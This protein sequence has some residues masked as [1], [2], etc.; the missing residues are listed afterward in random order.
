MPDEVGR[1]FTEVDEGAGLSAEQA[2]AGLIQFLDLRGY[3]TEP[4]GQV[5]EEIDAEVLWRAVSE[6]R[7][8]ASYTLME[9]ERRSAI[10]VALE[11]RE[12]GDE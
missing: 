8:I 12:S 2:E 3:H 7:D 11:R 5:V 10:W 4:V 1:I 9:L 6:L